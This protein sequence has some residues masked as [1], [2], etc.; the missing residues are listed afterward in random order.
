MPVNFIFRVMFVL[1]IMFRMLFFMAMLFF[2]MMKTLV[3]IAVKKFG[4]PDKCATAR[5][6]P[7]FPPRVGVIES[8]DYDLTFVGGIANRDRNSRLVQAIIISA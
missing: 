2:L 4:F 6:Q 3:D 8:I 5:L 7:F 1:V